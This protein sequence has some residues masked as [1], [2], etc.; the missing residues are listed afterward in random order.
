MAA[1]AQTL[2][3]AMEQWKKSTAEDAGL[4]FVFANNMI[5][6]KPGAVPWRCPSEEGQGAFPRDYNQLEGLTQAV[7]LI[8]R[9][10]IRANMPFC[11]YNLGSF[12]FWAEK[13]NFPLESA[14]PFP[15]SD[16]G[17]AWCWSWL[18]LCVPA[19]PGLAAKPKHKL[20]FTDLLKNYPVL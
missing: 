12:F 11:Y 14:A 17:Q 15:G 18:V 9:N 6:H 5:F 13:D 20:G 7:F 3:C 16:F 2:V 19:Q 10:T 8:P 4:Q 1:L